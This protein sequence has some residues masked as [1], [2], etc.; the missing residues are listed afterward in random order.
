[1]KKRAFICSLILMFFCVLNVNAA[2]TCDYKTQVQ[3]NTEAANI[4]TNYEVKEIKT[5]NMVESDLKEN[6]YEDETYVGVEVTIQNI[7]ENVYVEIT[8]SANDKIE[9]FHYKDTNDG[10]IVLHRGIDGL[11]DIVT[12]KIVIYS[13][14][15]DCLDEEL[16]KIEI[17]TP[18][19]NYFSVEPQCEKSN[20]YYCQEF[21]TEELNMSYEDFV[22][23]AN[24]DTKE[25]K[26]EEKKEASANDFWKKYGIFIIIGLVIVAMG[27]GTTVIVKLK[28][29]SSVK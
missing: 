27:V 19:Y 12:Y 29:R 24:K 3:L 4:K 2:S 8:N 21:I 17:K 5:G 18:K 20:K 26:E 15:R 28:Q 7:T 23:Q 10:T 13:D 9:V 1:M 14:Y 16:K 11:E 22:R 25:Q 6:E